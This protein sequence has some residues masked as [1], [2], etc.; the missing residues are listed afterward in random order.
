VRSAQCRALELSAAL[1]L[2][3]LRAAGCSSI[4]C[5]PPALL[6]TPTHHQHRQQQHDTERGA[7]CA[8]AV[9]FTHHHQYRTAHFWA[10]A[11]SACP[12]EARR[13]AL[14]LLGEAAIHPH[15]THTQPW[16][17]PGLNRPWTAR[18]PSTLARAAARYASSRSHCPWGT[19]ANL[20]CCADTGRGQSLRAWYVS[21]AP[22]STHPCIILTASQPATDGTSTVSAVTHAALCSIPTPICSC[23][24]TAPSFATTAPTVA[25][26]AATRSKT[27]PS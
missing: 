21:E 26:P 23:S 1:S 24:A 2:A 9:D 20:A 15:T 5:I 22:A 16:S 27:W 3:L 11:A 4:R 8:S 14:S 18:M 6:T 7:A 17:R 13:E 12:S 19:N 25:T 10:S